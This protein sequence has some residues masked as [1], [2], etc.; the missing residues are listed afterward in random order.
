MFGGEV[1]EERRDYVTL[2]LP[3]VLPPTPQYSRSCRRKKQRLSFYVKAIFWTHH[4]KQ[5]L[6]IHVLF[7][8]CHSVGHSS[9]TCDCVLLIR[10]KSGPGYSVL[11]GCA[12]GSLPM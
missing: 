11:G 4:K 10:V 6:V 7:S 8:Q 12:R 2:S 1:M 3:A 9:K 5:S